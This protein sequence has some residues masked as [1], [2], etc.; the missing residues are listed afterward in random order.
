MLWEPPSPVVFGPNPVEA[1]SVSQGDE[2]ISL[3]LSVSG[4]V[5]EDIMVFGAAPCSAGRKKCR[6]VAYLGLLPAPVGGVSDITEMY[7]KRYGE[8]EPGKRVFIRTR[9][10]RNGWEGHHKDTSEVVP[11]KPVVAVMQRRCGEMGM[12]LGLNELHGL[13]RLQ[14]DAVAGRGA[15]GM[16]KP[17]TREQYRGYTVV[18]PSQCRR[19]TGSPSRI[20]GIGPMRRLCA[21]AKVRRSGHWRELW[22]G[23]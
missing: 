1:L 9:Q 6:N 7:V 5:V 3:R 23:S 4:S 13:H 15:S 17:C 20:W 16:L 14:E 11:A 19:D 21:L 22:H 2:G 8:P 12:L 10:Q 18:S